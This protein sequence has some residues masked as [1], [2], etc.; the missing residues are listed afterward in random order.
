MSAGLTVP[1]KHL[2]G[3]EQTQL[4]GTNNSEVYMQDCNLVGTH[5]GNSAG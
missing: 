4:C 2:S 5:L 1:E 3:D